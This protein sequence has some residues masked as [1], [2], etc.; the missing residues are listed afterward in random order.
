MSVRGGVVSLVCVCVAS[1]GF[2]AIVAC[3][4][5]YL[6][7]AQPDPNVVT[8]DSTR[9]IFVYLTRTCILSD[10]R[11]T[12]EGSHSLRVSTGV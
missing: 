10:T 11:M 6:L 5:I 7:A 3:C 9:S 1:P 2:S 12:L 4:Y 8:S